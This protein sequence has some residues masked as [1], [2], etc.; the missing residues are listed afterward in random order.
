M[1]IYK[2][3]FEVEVSTASQNCHYLGSGMFDYTLG[4]YIAFENKEQMF[5]GAKDVRWR[6]KMAS[7]TFGLKVMKKSSDLDETVIGINQI[8][9][10]SMEEFA[11]LVE[12]CGNRSLEAH[13]NK[14]MSLAFK[15][16]RFFLKIHPS[17]MV[18]MSHNLAESLDMI[19]AGRIDNEHVIF[20]KRCSV[21]QEYIHYMSSESR[22]VSVALYDMIREFR[23]VKN[24]SRYP[25]LFDYSGLD[26]YKSYEL[27]GVKELIQRDGIRQFRFQLFDREMRAI[28]VSED[29]LT[30]PLEFKLV[31]LVL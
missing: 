28:D 1:N 4:Q 27:L 14:Q 5:V 15:H 19:H 3:I 16:D 2:T 31:F 24:G 9:Y 23:I 25:V 18:V 8:E 12:S 13:P 20:D 17:L 26:R 21:S 30:R 10:R 6:K 29:Y 7:M 22:S 11:M